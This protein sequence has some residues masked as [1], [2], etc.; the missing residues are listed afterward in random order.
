[1]ARLPLSPQETPSPFQIQ[2]AELNRIRANFLGRHLGTD[3]ANI[4]RYLDAL[5]PEFETLSRHFSVEWA[6]IHLTEEDRLI[7]VHAIV[8]NCQAH[9]VPP[10][11]LEVFQTLFAEEY[12]YE[13]WNSQIADPYEHDEL[14]ARIAKLRGLMSFF[15]MDAQFIDAIKKRFRLSLAVETVWFG[16]PTPQSLINQLDDDEKNELAEA[17]KESIELEKVKK[18]PDYRLKALVNAGAVNK[19]VLLL[20]RECREQVAATLTTVQRP[21]NE[22]DLMEREKQKHAEDVFTL[23]QKYDDPGAI[24]DIL[25]KA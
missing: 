8:E 9:G 15:S 1:M 5:P 7:G 10:K 18:D 24:I 14:R 21:A 20:S 17:I 6:L 13:D 11:F 16:V 12:Y 4:Q 25:L 2:L 3:P 22:P 23:L 19:S